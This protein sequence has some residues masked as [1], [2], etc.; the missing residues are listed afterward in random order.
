[1]A[2]KEDLRR[3]NREMR[4]KMMQRQREQ[5]LKDQE[6]IR[7]LAQKQ[8]ENK[9]AYIKKYPE[10][11]L[12]ILK[13]LKRIDPWSGVANM[14]PKI[15]C[16]VSYYKLKQLAFTGLRL[17]TNN[18]HS[19]VEFK[20]NDVVWIFDPST[21]RLRK[22]G[23]PIKKKKDAEEFE[24]TTLSFS[25]DNDTDY[26]EYFQNEIYLSKDELKILAMKDRGL[27]LIT[28]INYF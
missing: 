17:V 7:E 8:I 28:K 20:Y 22:L 26:I 27:Q 23:F 24:Y 2:N 4:H 1:M 16:L 11:I 6:R 13:R 25:F 14:D 21:V 12:T 3:R 5:I 10:L 19:W 18:S 9:D 15:G